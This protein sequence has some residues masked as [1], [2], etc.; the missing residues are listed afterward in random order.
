MK[1]DVPKEIM[2]QEYRVGLTPDAV[3]EYVAA[4]RAVIVESSA[5]VGIGATDDH[6]RKA[7]ATMVDAA[8]EIFASSQLI[9]TGQDAAAVPLASSETLNNATLPF[10]LA[11]ANNGFAAVLEIRIC[12][13]VSMCIEVS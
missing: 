13:Q 2:A 5:G 6:Y 12:A 9:V 3:H 7:G 1:V 4:G 10:G 8:R 11:L